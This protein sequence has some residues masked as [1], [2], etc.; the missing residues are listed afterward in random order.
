MRKLFTISTIL[1]IGMFFLS[2]NL[3][4]QIPQTIRLDVYYNGEDWQDFRSLN[5]DAYSWDHYGLYTKSQGGN[6]EGTSRF[7][8]FDY[9]LYTLV[10]SIVDIDDLN[11]TPGKEPQKYQRT[12]EVDLEFSEWYTAGL[13]VSSQNYS[14]K[15]SHVIISNV[16]IS[17]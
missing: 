6:D 11:P 8:L 1:I 5:N 4:A 16:Y 15:E 9:Y 13:V 14:F 3:F 12:G 17:K 10:E 2:Q 7:I